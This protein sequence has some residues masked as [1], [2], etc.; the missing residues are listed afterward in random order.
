MLPLMPVKPHIAIVG[1]GRLGGALAR[2]LLQTGHFIAEVVSRDQPASRRKARALA[3][4]LHANATMLPDTRLDAK[5]IWFCVPDREI[6]WA[7]RAL[8]HLDWQEKVAL[9]SSGALSS[10]ALHV[11][12]KRGASIASVHPLMTF[13][14]GSTPSLQGVPFALEGDRRA[15]AEARRI[16]GRLGGETFVLSQAA[17][18][19]YHAWATL[20]CPLLVSAL[21]TA[22][23]VAKRAG[24]P[25]SAARRNMMPIVGQTLKNYLT[26]G[27]ARAFSGP[28][29][30]GDVAVVVEHLRAL[31]RTPE[32]KS[33]YLALAR[34]ALRYLPAKN[35]RALKRV[36]SEA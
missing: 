36:L 30:R 15:R 13:V 3:K 9:H 20:V 28:L 31:E 10:D 25:A 29:V 2:A 24:V 14:S 32:A 22:E 33:I 5:V 11:L 12:R 35:R 23:Q 26:L 4:A 34:A 17:K 21:V 1:P 6:E 16:V 18:P 8:M 27:P 19:A 7:A